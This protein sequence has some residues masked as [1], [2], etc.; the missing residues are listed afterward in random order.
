MDDDF[1]A[2]IQSI[3]QEIARGNLEAP[4]QQQTSRFR[5]AGSSGPSDAPNSVFGSQNQAP[6]PAAP[7]SFSPAAMPF[8][9]TQGLAA[10]QTNNSFGFSSPSPFGAVSAFGGATPGAPGGP[11]GASPAPHHFSKDTDERSIFVGN[12]PKNFPVTPEEL[13]QFFSECGPIL[14]CTILK[15]RVTQEP[16]GTAYIE[17]GSYASM[18]KAIDSMNN[19]VFKGSPLIVC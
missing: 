14:H 10:P 18:G 15:D 4:Q 9:P 5:F 2:E 16:K 3:E 1:A 13:M 6:A 8:Q 11:G 17:F 7:S 12:L 19:A